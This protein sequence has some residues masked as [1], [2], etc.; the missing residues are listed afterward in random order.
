MVTLL[1]ME[2]TIRLIDN[3]LHLCITEDTGAMYTKGFS[4]I[5]IKQGGSATAHELAE[6]GHTDRDQAVF[7]ASHPT[8]AVMFPFVA[9]T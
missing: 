8:P 2:R 7:A 5:A 4:R 1:Y 9:A 6:L 3:M